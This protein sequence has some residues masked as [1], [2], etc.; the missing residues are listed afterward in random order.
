MSIVLV[1]HD[2]CVVA[3]TCTRVAVLY[4]GRIMETG[5]VAEVFRKPAHAYTLGLLGAVPSSHRP[6]R[7]LANIPGAPPHPFAL[8]PGC[9]FAPRCLLAEPACAAGRW[10]PVALGDGR[11]SACLRHD[12]VMAQAQPR[13]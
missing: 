5:P 12:L 6:R 13:Q 4:A 9:R 7:A 11:A 8:P 3:Q 1:T 2:L 10:A